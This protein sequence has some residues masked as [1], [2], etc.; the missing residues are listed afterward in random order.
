MNLKHLEDF[1]AHENQRFVCHAAAAADDATEQFTVQIEHVV[2]ASLTGDDQQALEAQ[3]NACDQ[4]VAFYREFPSLRLYCDTNS[5]SSAF[6]LARPRK[7]DQLKQELLSWIRMLHDEDTH[8]ALPGWLDSA[9][10]FGEIPEASNYLVMPTEG[11]DASKVFLFEHGTLTFSEQAGDFP[12]YVEMI[13]TPTA[14]L[15]AEIRKHTQYSDG[16]TATK[17]LVAEF[18]YGS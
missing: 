5:S 18:A 8:G 15:L 11:D 10:V 4:L 12:G 16:S 6:Y 9:V 13:T 14:S 2:G 7:W 17:W 3:H 1:L